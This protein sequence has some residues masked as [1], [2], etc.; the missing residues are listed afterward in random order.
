M[1]SDCSP[2]SRRLSPS[3]LA[4]ASGSPSSFPPLN[5]WQWTAAHKNQT[6]MLRRCKWAGKEPTQMSVCT[7]LQPWWQWLFSSV[8]DGGS[9]RCT[10]PPSQDSKPETKAGNWEGLL[11]QEMKQMLLS[12]KRTGSMRKTWE[13]AVRLSPSPPALSDR[14]MM[15]GLSAAAFW[16][17]RMA[18]VLLFWVQEPSKRTKLKP[19]SLMKREHSS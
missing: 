2:W 9:G 19:C 11:L 14:S 8:P 15:V 13:A 7:L 3:G 16:N 5:L 17:S 18:S 10:A 6:F 4:S 1:F 12:S